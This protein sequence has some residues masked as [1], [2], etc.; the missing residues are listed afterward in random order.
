MTTWF[1]LF[2]WVVLGR[3]L[4]SV[5]ADTSRSLA[6]GYPEPVPGNLISLAAERRKRRIA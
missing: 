1:V 5:A 6:G 3:V 4:V 2:G